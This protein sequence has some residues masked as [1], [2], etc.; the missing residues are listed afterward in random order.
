MAF[1]TWLAVA[2]ERRAAVELMR[3]ARA[4]LAQ[5][6]QRMAMTAGR[7]AAELLGA[8]CARAQRGVAELRAAG[9]ALGRWVEVAREVAAAAAGSADPRARGRVSTARGDGG[10]G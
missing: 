8:P 4:A 2:A 10:D 9:A 5:R 6:G 3:R 7:D 1:N